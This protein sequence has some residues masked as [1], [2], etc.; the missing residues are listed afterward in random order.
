VTSELQLPEL[1]PPQALWRGAV[2]ALVVVLPLAVL[3]NVVVAGGEPASSP[4]VLALFG[5]TLLGGAAGGWATIRLSPAAGLPYAAGAAALAYVV[6]Q[7]VGVV[8]RLLRGDDL[9]LAGYPFLALLMATC[10][11]LGGMFARRWQAGGD[12][13]S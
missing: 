10:G 5:L 6:A 13:A 7:G 3:N 11:M 2:T 8:L 4:L 12:E 1:S 9:K